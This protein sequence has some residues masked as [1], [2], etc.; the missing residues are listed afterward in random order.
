MIRVKLTGTQAGQVDRFAINI[1]TVDVASRGLWVYGMTAGGQISR[2]DPTNLLQV[3][4]TVTLPAQTQ[5]FGLDVDDSG[6]FY[7]TGK[8][9][10]N[11]A[12]KRQP[13]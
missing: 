10:L 13:S 6:N 8:S 1:G 9:L 3:G 7:T 12:R 4:S 5:Y 2:F 11:G